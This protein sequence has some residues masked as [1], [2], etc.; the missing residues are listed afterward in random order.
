MKLIIIY[1]S[2]DRHV[3]LGKERVGKVDH[4]SYILNRIAGSRTSPECIGANVH[5][6][7]SMLYRLNSYIGITGRCKKLYLAQWLISRHLDS[8]FCPQRYK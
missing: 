7:G 1:N 6:I 2:V 8:M 4:F 3:D 5:R